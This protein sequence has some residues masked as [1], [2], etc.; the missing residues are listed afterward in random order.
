ML[1]SAVQGVSSSVE[2]V[3]PSVNGLPV[4]DIRT[5]LDRILRS[6][7][8]V[9]SHRIR[10]F[11]QFV[12]EECLSGRHH[13]LKEYLIGLEVFTRQDSFDPR[14]DSIVR[15]EARR[16]RAKLDEYYAAEGQDAAIRI[17]LRKGSYVPAF[18]TAARARMNA[19]TG[20][21]TRSWKRSVALT[22]LFCL[23]IEQAPFANEVRRRL[24]HRLT[25]EPALQVIERNRT[26][27]FG[28]TPGALDGVQY[29]FLLDGSLETD[30]SQRRLLLQL[31]DVGDR[32]WVWSEEIDYT[33]GDLSFCDRIAAAIKRAITGV[34]S[35]SEAERRSENRESFTAWLQGLYCWNG[36]KGNALANS[37][38]FF[39]HAVETDPHYAAAWAAL[40][41]ALTGCAILDRGDD[42]HAA[43]K[44]REAAG[45]AMEL[46]DA[47]PESHLARGV[48]LSFLDW[49]W[50]EGAKEL[51]RAI[52]ID[53]NSAGCRHVLGIQLACRGR[54]QDARAAF[55]EAERLNPVSLISQFTQGW[56]EALERR[57]DEAMSRYRLIALLEPDFPWS[58]VGMGQACAAKGNWTEAIAHFT[59]VSHLLGSRF[60]FSGCLGYCYGRAGRRDEALRL[61]GR[62]GE[63]AR[64]QHVPLAN[65]A[66]IYAGLGETDR[67]FAY[68]REAASKRECTL[69]LLLLGP[70]FAE[71]RGHG[72]WASVMAA[73]G[74]GS[75]A[76]RAA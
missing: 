25:Q 40:A 18:E 75:P 55:A 1:D 11:L 58:Y 59:N 2:S 41:E 69:P 10:R 3:P 5:E 51:E 38:P 44:A 20:A 17:Q 22:P 70:E 7:V 31:M 33:P 12:V 9:H 66:S 39:A 57:Y 50:E 32:A 34:S 76:V 14:V 21:S 15:V 29:D 65:Y 19:A 35:E 23:D 48:V 43:A 4:T 30:G 49:K 54:L 36:H 56:I 6:R 47:L 26:S 28:E 63:Y 42:A 73:I 16:L 68:L 60:L 62:L 61:M 13:R 8:F 74:M 71:L 64:S 24:A 53:P 67:A 37:V 52:C 46:N 27:E 72:E 45:K